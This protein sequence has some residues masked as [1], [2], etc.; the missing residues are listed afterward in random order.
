MQNRGITLVELLIAL[1]VLGV[2]FG[3]LVFSQVTNY[4]ATARA[5]VVSQVKD[6]ATQILENQVGVVLANFT[7]YYNGCPTGSETGCYG[8]G[9]L[10]NS[11]IDEG[12]DGEGQILIQSSATSQGITIN[13]ATKVSCYDGFAS[14]T[15]AIG[16]GSLEPCPRPN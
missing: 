4:R 15:A 9:F 12:L 10:I 2:A 7:R 8:S 3:V 13:L 16:V 5:G 14:R 11:G 6:T 1:A